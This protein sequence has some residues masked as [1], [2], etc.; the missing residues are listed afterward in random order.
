YSTFL[1]NNSAAYTIALVAASAEYT[2]AGG[3]GSEY[4]RLLGVAVTVGGQL[5]RWAA[6]ISAGSNFTHRIRLQ[7]E[8]EQQLITTGAY[9]LCRHPGYSG[10][11]W[12][13]VGTQLL[14]CNRLCLG[15][16]TACARWFFYERLRFEE[17]TLEYFY[18]WDYV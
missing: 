11:F 14:L 4:V 6:F 15:L 7:K 10:W 13:A 8:G 16:Y 9:R 17:R 18:K 1:V 5:L 12:W 2:L 3:D